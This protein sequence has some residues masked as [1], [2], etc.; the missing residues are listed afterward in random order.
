[1]P[2]LLIKECADSK[3]IFFFLSFVTFL[4]KAKDKVNVPRRTKFLLNKRI[5]LVSPIIKVFAQLFSK[6]A[7][8]FAYELRSR[9]TRGGVNRAGSAGLRGWM[10]RG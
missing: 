5:S 1:M 9:D 10:M 7:Y 4:W 3:T 2:L 6:S 8:P